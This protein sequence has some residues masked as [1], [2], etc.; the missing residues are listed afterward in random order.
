M[1]L[2]AI[3][4]ETNPAFEPFC[5]TAAWR[6]EDGSIESRYYELSKPDDYLDIRHL[7]KMF[8]GGFVFHNAKFDLMKLI[9]C[10]LLD[11]DVDYTMFH[12]TETLS[13]LLDPNRRRGLKHLASEVLGEST[14]EASVL[15]ATFRKMGL[16]KSDGFDKLPREILI[17]YA[18]KDA[19]YTLRLSE[20]FLEEFNRIPDNDSIKE[21]Y[22]LERELTCALMSMEM[23]GIGVDVG[24]LDKAYIEYS[25]SLG[26]LELECFNL[27]SSEKFNPYSPVKVREALKER[28]INVEDTQSVTLMDYRD[29][30]FV[31]A[32]LEL[33]STKIICTTYLTALKNETKNG[34]FKGNFRQHGASTGRMSSG[35]HDQRAR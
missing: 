17:P 12:D 25:R 7:I 31:A 21:L 29:D 18:I 3:D 19:E 11:P 20:V 34:V 30:P 5:V 35:T 13:H 27:A 1:K 8:D 23:R 22:D 15:N 33:R 26:L 10:C 16:K 9:E 14:D 4:T 28:G 6:E 24:Y 32:L 2:L